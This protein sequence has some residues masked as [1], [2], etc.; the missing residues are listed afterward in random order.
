[1]TEYRVRRRLPHPP[2]ILFDLVA[3]VERYPDFVP[4]YKAAR[5]RDRKPAGY[6]T[7]QVIKFDPVR[8]SFTSRTMLRR[9]DLIEIKAINGPFRAFNFRWTFDH[10]AEGGCDIGVTVDLDFR[11]SVLSRMAGKIGQTFADKC[12][13][14]FEKEATRRVAV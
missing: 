2:E 12:I 4:W 3:D 5:V 11:S 13:N 14:V 1:M 6:V 7:D 10:A 9:P 8:Q